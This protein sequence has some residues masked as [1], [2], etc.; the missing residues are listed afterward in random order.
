MKFLV[1][2]MQRA[3]LTEEENARLYSAMNDFYSRIPPNVTL[4]C[5]YV[6]A[7]RLGSYSVLDVPDRAALDAI[8]VPFTGLVELETVEVVT[9]AE[10][11]PA[12]S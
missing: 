6:R 4:E 7:D 1:R 9:T 12:S 8:L 10:S 11:A 3:G 2:S 5:D